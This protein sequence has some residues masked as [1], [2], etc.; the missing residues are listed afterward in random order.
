[1]ATRSHDRA[2]GG[3]GKAKR[4]ARK[5]AIHS[6]KPRDIFFT[7]NSGFVTFTDGRWVAQ[8]MFEL[9][10]GKLKPAD[11][12]PLRVIRTLDDGRLFS[13]DNRR[14]FALRAMK[15]NVSILVELL[16]DSAGSLQEYQL[17]RFGLVNGT[18]SAGRE[19]V[20]KAPAT[21]KAGAAALAALLP[22]PSCGMEGVP[23]IKRA[24]F[25]KGSKRA[26]IASGC[27]GCIVLLKGLR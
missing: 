8:T 23:R 1:M 18:Q 17:K 27:T 13:L 20:L 2:S 10:S 16:D 7:Q 24:K 5:R 22:C 12:P 6:A 15:P 21:G 9:A 3:G 11:L 4:A 19:L 26:T 25:A 14:L